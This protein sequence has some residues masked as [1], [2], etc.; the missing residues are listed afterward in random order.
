[1][2]S[3]VSTKKI[4]DLTK[5]DV[6]KAIN[7]G[8]GGL[9]LARDYGVSPKTLH[10]RLVKKFG[11]E[12]TVLE[13]RL[14][15]NDM[16]NLHQR[17]KQRLDANL[18]RM[19]K[20]RQ[21]GA[22]L[23]S[24]QAPVIP[25]QQELSVTTSFRDKILFDPPDNKKVEARIDEALTNEVMSDVKLKYREFCF[26]NALNSE[27]ASE[28][29]RIKSLR[30]RIVMFE[31]NIANMKTNIANANKQISDL[32]FGI[33]KNEERVERANDGIDWHYPR[34]IQDLQ[35]KIDREREHI[36]SYTG[37]KLERAKQNLSEYEAKLS[38]AKEKPEN[39]KRKIAK[40]QSQIAGDRAI[41]A[42]LSADLVVFRENIEIF[43]NIIAQTEAE[44]EKLMTPRLYVKEFEEGLVLV[45]RHC[46][47]FDEYMTGSN[48]TASQRAFLGWYKHVQA[49]CDMNEL[50]IDKDIFIVVAKILFLTDRFDER[51]SFTI[52]YDGDRSKI[53]HRIIDDFYSASGE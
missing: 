49:Y 2:K 53:V 22:L 21:P 42:Q 12:A 35:E 11:I 34:E 27:M 1:M 17:A 29:A 50:Q 10:E 15:Q 43:K 20:K 39:A 38:E 52:D 16:Q 7:D 44:I 5:E 24:E 40:I 51:K 25:I 14:T 26:S 19:T 31:E 8:I 3:R 13:T 23:L 9:D 47:T 32:E 36:R 28:D 48:S 4:G 30:K 33:R 18:Q 41:I 46:K 45:C 37:S 6:E